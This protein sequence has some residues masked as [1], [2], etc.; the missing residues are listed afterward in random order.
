MKALYAVALVSVTLL[1]GPAFSQNAGGT[2][3]GA[4]GGA[5]VGTLVGARS[6]RLSV[7][8]LAHLSALHL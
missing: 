8:P 6:V 1:S 3:G 7:A 4:V 2:V 5:A